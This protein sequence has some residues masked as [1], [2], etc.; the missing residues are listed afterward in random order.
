MNKS[1]IDCFTFSSD[2]RYIFAGTLGGEILS[3]EYESFEIKFKNKAHSGNTYAIAVAKSGNYLAS[4]GLD[5]SLTISSCLKTGKTERLH[6]VSLRSLFPDNVLPEVQLVP[7]RDYNQA[8]A[9][10]PSQNRIAVRTA[11]NA[12][13]EFTFSDNELRLVHCSRFHEY[14]TV[15]TLRYINNNNDLLIGTLGEI[16]ISNESD[17][18]SR[19]RVGEFNIH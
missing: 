18:I 3:I 19:H 16:S 9:F 5:R 4:L 1:K 12:I 2:Q 13:A 7:N 6:R 8:I 14:S 11:T 17:L 10:H 15:M